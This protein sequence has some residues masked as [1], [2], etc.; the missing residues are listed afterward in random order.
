MLP[1]VILVDIIPPQV[2]PE[3]SLARLNELERLVDTYGGFVVIRKIQRKQMPN[4]RTYIG[5]GK[6][7][8]ILKT[9]LEL[10]ASYLIVNNQMKPEQL[11]NLEKEFTDKHQIKVWDKIDLILA[12][13]AKHAVTKEAKLQIELAKLRH[14]GPRISKMGVELMR[15]GAGIGTRGKGETNIE[16]MKRHIRLRERGVRNELEKVEQSQESQRKKR[17]DHGFRTV[18]IVGYT[19]AGKSQLLKSL[20][21]KEVK[22]KDEL[23]ATLDSR[24]GKLYLPAARTECLVS[25]TIGFIRDLPPQLIDAFHSTL[26]ETVHADLILHVIDID[27]LDMEWKIKVVHEVLNTL[28]CGGKKIVY[29]FNKIDLLQLDRH[30]D[31][32]RRFALYDPVFVSAKDKTNLDELKGKIAKILFP[33]E[34]KKALE[35]SMA[36]Q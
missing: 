21:K 35:N 33:L 8:E 1:K 26:S 32:E 30:E 6:V 3:D 17:H 9:A 10:K 4:Y 18:A 24:I 2:T 5:T 27:D 11:Y 29:V 25:D 31:L 15:Q 14:F 23:F 36:L 20:T 19:N 13:F 22:V 28:K 16:I 34:V 12:I 7:E